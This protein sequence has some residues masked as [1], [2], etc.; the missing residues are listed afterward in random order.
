VLLA[1]TSA[2]MSMSR[3]AAL[4]GPPAVLVMVVAWSW[5]RRAGDDD[6]R[7]RLR[8]GLLGGV[9]GTIGYDLVRVPFHL[10]GQNPFVP[11]RAYGVWL[12]GAS[13]SSPLTD[14]VGILYHASNG[15][16]FAWLYAIVALRRHWGWAVVW[17]LALESGAVVTSFGDVFAI[18][19]VYGAL[20]LAYAAHV[21]YGAPL[22]RVCAHPER[23]LASVR[24]ALGSARSWATMLAAA[25]FVM[26][27]LTAW[28]APGA[29]RGS[30]AAAASVDVGPASFYPG[31]LERKRGESF[32]LRNRLDRPVEV[33]VR[34]P[35]AAAAE[36]ILVQLAPREA[37]TVLLTEIGIHQVLAPGLP[38]R[39]AFVAVREGADYRPRAAAR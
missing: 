33:R 39:S 24:P 27:F 12:L 1:Q 4:L 26:W 2:W 35:G 38:W 14:A 25:L 17:A 19:A 32:A 15:I 7:L 9:W 5:A 22:G 23:A 29:D 18:R 10:A 36:P 11:I 8:A 30:A 3:A 20:A 31:W 6:L 37:R 16:A 13:A 21:F 28:Q 34:P